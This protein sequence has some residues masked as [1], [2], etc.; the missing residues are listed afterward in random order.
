MGELRA[1]RWLHLIGT[2]AF[3]RPIGPGDHAWWRPGA[4]LGLMLPIGVGLGLIGYLVGGLINS[5]LIQALVLGETPRWPAHLIAAARSSLVT[6]DSCLLGGVTLTVLVGVIYLAC[7]IA[8]LTSLVIVYRR[9]ARTWVT[10]AP[11]F[12]WRLFWIGLVLF[13]VIL[14]A[15]ASI[16]EALHGWPDRPVFLK[17]DEAVR[18]RIAYVAVTLIALPIAAAF[19]EI[20]CRGWL[21]Q[22]TAAFT[23]SLPAILLFNSLFFSLLHVDPDPGRNLSRAV[24]GIALSWGVLRTGGLE[25]GIG[26]HTANNLVILMLAQTLQHSETLTASTPLSVVINLSVCLAAVAVIEVIMRWRP[27]RRWTGLEASD[28]PPQPPDI[29]HRANSTLA[30]P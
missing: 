18:M 14:A 19:E 11:R 10:S 24:L 5:W 12:R 23:R 9:P 8:L 17:A 27:L 20:L 16:P 30:A 22:V 28:G 1:D 26:I 13:S 15:I 29:P 2:P 3:L 21:L 4:A 6:C 7:L 25:I